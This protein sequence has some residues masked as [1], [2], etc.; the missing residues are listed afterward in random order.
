MLLLFGSHVT[1]PVSLVLYAPEMGILTRK[2]VLRIKNSRNH[3]IDQVLR[4]R[5]RRNAINKEKKTI[6]RKNVRNIL[7]DQEI[8]SKRSIEYFLI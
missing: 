4:K 8:S 5:V 7:I 6:L 1:E 2:N 3:A